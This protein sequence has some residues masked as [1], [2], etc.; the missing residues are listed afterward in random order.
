MKKRVLDFSRYAFV[1]FFFVVAAFLYAEYSSYEAKH[2]RLQVT[3]L[4]KDFDGVRQNLRDKAAAV[5]AA[6]YELRHQEQKLN[7]Y[8]SQARDFGI[9][10]IRLYSPK[11]VLRKNLKYPDAHI[12]GETVKKTSITT[13]SIAEKGPDFG[14]DA[15]HAFY[16]FV[17]TDI[18]QSPD[19]DPVIIT[20]SIDTNYVLKLLNSRGVDKKLFLLKRSYLDKTLRQQHLSSRFQSSCLSEDFLLTTLRQGKEESKI[21]QFLKSEVSP[22]IDRNEAF[23]VYGRTARDVQRA[24]FLPVRDHRQKQIG[25]LVSVGSDDSLWQ[26]AKSSGLK[27]LIALALFAFL[28]I[29]YSRQKAAAK[30]L[31]QMKYFIDESTVVA[32][33]DLKG[34]IT[35]GNKAFEKLCGY[36]AEE[37]YKTP[38]SDLIAP[39]HREIFESIFSSLMQGK[40]WRGKL[41]HRNKAGGEYIVQGSIFA[42][43]DKSSRLREFIFIS[44]DVTKIEKAREQKD[45]LLMH[46]SKLASIGEMVD[47]VA[48][49]WKQP[50]HILRMKIDMLHHDFKDGELDET[51][52]HE[53]H[54]QSFAQFDHMQQT[55][56]TFRNFLRPGGKISTIN[57]KECFEDVMLLIGDDLQY[58]NIQVC[59]DAD[60]EAVVNGNENE[61]KHLFLNLLSNAKDAFK[62][63]NIEH[64]KITVHIGQSRDKV[65]VSVSDNAGGI[66]EEVLPSVF[67]PHITT[68]SKGTGM[69]LYMSKKIAKKLGGDLYAKNAS[70]GA[71]FTFVIPK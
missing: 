4:Q 38:Y 11:G 53:F 7:A 65:S 61:V 52:M 2:N 26:L 51:L 45:N 35:Y 22:L 23:S 9:D 46:Q 57:V 12:P 37:L 30:E 39:D 15:S 27:L 70:Q 59:I 36:R 42:V 62:A 10:N 64:K 28:F 60:K 48:H 33:F 68:K 18:Y 40:T 14:F 6:V 24:T 63:K 50:I 16:G 67:E 44:H 31:A 49:Q 21:G 25:Y 56:D 19:S 32:K 71:V 66:P 69:G 1:L 13:K 54:T 5:G 43:Y 55:L 34:E 58:A 29:I 17:Y 47:L 20:V 41:T 3:N 8:F